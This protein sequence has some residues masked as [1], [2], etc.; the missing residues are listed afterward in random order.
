MDLKEL[1]GVEL[2][3]LGREDLHNDKRETIGAL[4][5][6]IARI[7]EQSAI[8]PCLICQLLNIMATY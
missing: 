6:E 8:A 5:I 2:I 4:P 1:P 3:L 7:T